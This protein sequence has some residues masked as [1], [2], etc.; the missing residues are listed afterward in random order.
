M[1]KD[2]FD[3]LEVISRWRRAIARTTLIAAVAGAGVSLLLPEKWTATTTLLPPEEEGGAGLG[4]GLLMG[5]GVPPGLAGLVG[6]STPS[7]RLITLLESRRVLGGV[8]DRF[9]LVTVYGAEHRDHAMELLSKDVEKELGRDGSLRIETTA[10]TPHLAADMANALSA[11]LDSVNRIHRQRQAGSM[12]SFL[13]NRL[14][15]TR[16]DLSANAQRLQ[17]FQ[18]SHRIVDIEAQIDAAVEVVKGIVLRLSLHQAEL[19]A[20]SQKLSEQH[21]DRQVMEVKVAELE[22]QLQV[23]VGDLTV[24]IG[25]GRAVAE[26]LGPPLRRMPDLMHDYAELTLELKV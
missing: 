15:T 7:E 21:P 19:G 18:E 6:V 13:E 5:S 2:V 20:M 4:L 24:D 25:P 8:V 11:A 9:H 1:T 26:S 14:Q 3:H 22:R 12:R 10:G 23:L 16:A 17:E